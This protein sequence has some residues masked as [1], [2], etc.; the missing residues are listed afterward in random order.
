MSR[1][2]LPSIQSE[3]MDF[4]MEENQ[5]VNQQGN[6]AN[7]DQNQNQNESLGWR[8]ALPSEF[9]ENEFVK[10]FTKPGDFVKSALEIKADRDALKTKVDGAIFKPDEKATPEQKEAYYRA[11]GKP[12]KST[13]YEFPKGE[14]VEHDPKL[15][16]WA[17][18]TFHSA[19]LDKGQAKVIGQAWDGFIGEMAKANDEAVKVAKTNAETAIKKELGAEYPVAVELAKRMLNKYTKPEEKAF[20]DESGMG[21]HPVLIRMLFDFAK[22]TGE[23]VGIPAATFQGEKPKEGIVYDKSPAPPK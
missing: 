10:T 17:Q 16:D 5:Q 15:T 2:L 20:F 7:Q 11:L 21:N 19:N 3:R 4:K 6:Q 14:G 12:E 9:K 8:A 1:F 18:K 23:D 13:E 22:K